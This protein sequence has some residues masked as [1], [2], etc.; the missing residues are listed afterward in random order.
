M[1]TETAMPGRDLA[2]LNAEFLGLVAAGVPVE[3]PARAARRLSGLDVEVHQRLGALPFAL[4]GYGF[5]DEPGWARLLSPGVRDLE[6]PYARGDAGVERFTLL[7]L[8]TLR[9]FARIAPRS[10]SAW[11]GL[12]VATRARLAELDIGLLP[13]VAALAAPRLRGHLALRECGWLQLLDAAEREDERQLELFA[14]LGKQW[15]IRRALG[16]GGP[17]QARRAFGR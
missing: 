7:A 2:A 10:A 5:E 9:G 13:P 17:V 4:F 1:T 16:I 14:A 11:S 8:T 12:P 6:P 3:L 15:T